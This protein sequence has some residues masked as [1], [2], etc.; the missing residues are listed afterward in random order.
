[1]ASL[2]HQG[3]AEEMS[4]QNC[5]VTRAQAAWSLMLMAL[6]TAVR[7]DE[8]CSANLWSSL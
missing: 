8:S 2:F 4:T 6:A 5:K 3:A 7:I 1:M